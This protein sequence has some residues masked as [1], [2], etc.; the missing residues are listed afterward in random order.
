MLGEELDCSLLPSGEC[1]FV[2]LAAV[3]RHPT[4]RLVDL[5]FGVAYR[6]EVTFLVG[7]AYLVELA[8]RQ[9]FIASTVTVTRVLL[10]IWI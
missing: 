4:D 1:Q 5:T 7:A 2:S 9:D 8:S 10:Q 6:I 3:V